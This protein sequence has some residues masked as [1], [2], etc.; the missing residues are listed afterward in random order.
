MQV[1]RRCAAHPQ[2][3]SI[4][5]STSTIF[6]AKAQQRGTHRILREII[7]RPAADIIQVHQVVEVTHL[8]ALPAPCCLFQ[9]HFRGR[10]EAG[11]QRIDA[12][13]VCDAVE[14]EEHAGSVGQHDLQA[15][16][17]QQ[18]AA[19]V[20]HLDALERDRLRHFGDVVQL[21]GLVVDALLGDL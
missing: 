4:F 1:D 14:D 9:A 2:T 20:D 10:V 11:H 5:P 21:C 15:H 16:G 7:H 8:P 12:L 18:V 19:A 3:F 17:A 13:A 6:T